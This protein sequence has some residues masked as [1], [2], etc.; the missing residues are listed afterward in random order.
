MTT[1][2]SDIGSLQDALDNARRATSFR[3]SSNEAQ[4]AHV[5]VALALEVLG[6]PL[7]KWTQVALGEIDG[8][9]IDAAREALNPQSSGEWIASGEVARAFENHLAKRDSG[10][11]RG[12]RNS[13]AYFTPPDLIDLVVEQTLEP[14]LATAHTPEDVLALRVFDPAVGAGGF[15]L[16]AARLLAGHVER[17]AG[18]DLTP[19]EARR[20]V[21]KHCL[22]GADA[23]PLAV[24]LTAAVLSWYGSGDGDLDGHVQWADTI[25]P[26][27]LVPI[28]G[29]GAPPLD[30]SSWFQNSQ[31]GFDAVVGNPPWGAVKPA[32]REFLARS[33]PTLLEWQGADLRERMDPTSEHSMRWNNHAEQVRSYARALRSSSYYAYQGRGDAELYRYFVERAHQLLDAKGGRLGLLIPGAFLRADGATP[34]RNLLFDTGSFDLIVEFINSERIFDIHSMFRFVM[35]TWEKGRQKGIDRAEFG[36]RSVEDARRILEDPPTSLTLAFLDRVGGPRRAV[37]D[38]RSEREAGLL[39]KTYSLHPTLEEPGCGWTPTFVREL[40]MTNDSHH[41]VHASDVVD[42]TRVVPLYEGRMV[43]QFDNRAKRYE[44]GAGRKAVWYPQE[45]GQRI[46]APHFFVPHEVAVSANGTSDRAGFCD[47]TGHA[48]E[49]T[50]LAALIPANAVAGNKVPTVRFDEPDR[51][52]LH[53]IWLALANSFV[54]DWIARRRVATSLNFFQLAQLPFPRIDSSTDLGA[55]IVDLASRLSRD[56]EHW[57]LARLHERSKMRAT[58]DAIVATCFGLDLAELALLLGDFPLLD[59]YQL[60]VGNAQRSTITRDLVLLTYAESLGLKSV[61]LADV[62]LTQDEGPAE[63][64]ERMACAHEYS[65]IAYVPGEVA[66]RL[67]S[68]RR[69]PLGSH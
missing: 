17:L 30:I 10:T 42:S 7:P 46:L 56:V 26:S 45:L 61:R 3:L 29:M 18:G 44:E 11:L 13:G 62:G 58:L 52:D 48:N 27:T 49:R 64:E 50:I 34:L 68:N 66:K 24:L 69:L 14:V 1:V 36:V 57:T 25:L 63:L 4:V 51:A 32:I 53:L 59:R 33:E 60:G 8:D 23:N 40:D 5:W 15:L 41:F 22:Y 39:E 65:Q 9:A 31:E 55:Q 67:W 37:P 21:V 12:R 16:S 6:R 19:A 28:M 47:V 35:L 2:A 54:I 20:A 38:I 43:H